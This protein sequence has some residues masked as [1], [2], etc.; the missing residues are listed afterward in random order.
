M[1][2]LL[3]NIFICMVLLPIA[4]ACQQQP[5]QW[6]HGVALYSFNRFPFAEALDKAKS[7]GV[8]Y[9]EGFS[10]HKLGP[11]F[12]DSALLTL[13][14]V[15]IEEMKALLDERGL[16]M[17]SMYLGNA[18]TEAAWTTA[19]EVGQKLG[20]EF[21]VCEPDPEDADLLNDL[22]GRYGIRIAI[23]QHAEGR[24]RY[25]HPDSVL[26]VMEGREHFGVCGDLGHWARSGLDPV[27]CLKTLEGKLISVHA[28]DL[29]GA[30]S[31]D[32]HDVTMGTGVIRYDQVFEELA[33]Q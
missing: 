25:W 10:F 8:T 33:R 32:A 31:M 22:A 19:F 11:A 29:D 7:T 21:F 28:K 6:D 12:G 20:L 23:H 14:D 24:S 30:G 4:I 17:R 3:R 16:R 27:T 1:K 18:K 5:N 13:S 2:R 15:Q 9:V 26:A